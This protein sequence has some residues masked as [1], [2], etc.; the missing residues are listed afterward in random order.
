MGVSAS[1]AAMARVPASVPPP[2]RLA[3]APVW[4][5]EVLAEDGAAPGRYRLEYEPFGGRLVAA[6]RQ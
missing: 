3:V 5:V 1:P 2:P 6:V 4:V